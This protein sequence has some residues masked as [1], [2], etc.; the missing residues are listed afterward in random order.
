MENLNLGQIITTPQA[1]DAIHIA[2]VPVVAD[3]K[4]RPGEKVWLENGKARLGSINSIGVVDPF[5]LGSVEP[6][7]TF[8]LF[9]NPGSITSLRHEWTHPAFAAPAPIP[10]DKSA[11][12]Q[13]LRD[14]AQRSDCPGYFELM[15]KAAAFCDGDTGW[16]EEYLHFDGSDAHGE[17]PPE[18][19]T[20]FEVVTGK[21]P[22]GAKPTYF[23]CSC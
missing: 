5:L 8:W 6:G 15:G 20:H 19:W 2:V 4:L 17:I 14:F 11:S 18:F 7:Q 23:S 21:R 22:E 9:L 16:S 12:E 1:R 10:A 3:D 13:W